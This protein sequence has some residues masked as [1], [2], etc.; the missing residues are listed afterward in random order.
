MKY[1]PFVAT[2]I[3][4]V[5]GEVILF[6]S[7]VMAQSPNQNLR[8][9]FETGRPQ[10]QDTLRFQ[11]PPS[12]VP[13]IRSNANN[14]QLIV[15]SQGNVS[16]WMPPGILAQDNVTIPTAAGNLNFQTLTS[17]DDQYRYVAAYATGLTPQQ[18][19]DPMV[20]FTAMRA[21]VA[22]E[23]TFSLMNERPVSLGNYQGSE[24]TFESDVERVTFRTYL[25]G[26]KIYAMG[27]I[28]PLNSTRDNA[29]RAF[30]NAL[31]LIDG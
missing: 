8:S 13:P 31:Q 2:V 17:T 11:R 4:A 20:L 10:S 15:F 14:W 6:P 5:V 21:R 28:Q 30:L 1:L 16:F 27:V 23:E 7:Q 26:D 22:P 12:G 9:F 3:T 19:S 18:I 25:V 29:S 24:F